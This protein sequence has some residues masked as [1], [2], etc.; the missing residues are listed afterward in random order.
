MGRN[1]YAIFENGMDE[2]VRRRQLIELD[3]KNALE[4]G[5]FKVHYQPRLN[6]RTGK[7]ASYEALIRWHHPTRG[8]VSPAEFI[9]VAE[10]CGQIIKIGEWVLRTACLAAARDMKSGRVSVNASP[11]QVRDKNFIETVRRALED[12]SGAVSSRDRDH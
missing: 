7:I 6:T 5:Q 1:R 2:H 3:L 12:R 9:P 11:F 8:M 10:G 4:D